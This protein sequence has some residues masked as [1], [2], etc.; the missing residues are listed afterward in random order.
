MVKLDSE[1]ARDRIDW[2]FL[3]VVLRVIGLEEKIIDLILFSVSS[4]V[5]SVLWNGEKLE[6]FSP[7]MGL[8]QGDLLSLHLFVL[9]MEVLSQWICKDMQEKK[10]ETSKIIVW[11]ARI[12]SCVLC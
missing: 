1:K 9:C 5:H 10:V 2:E 11:E 7:Q 4:A 3:R 6:A 8:R 12:I